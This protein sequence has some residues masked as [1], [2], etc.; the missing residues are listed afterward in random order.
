MSIVGIYVE[1][2]RLLAARLKQAKT[3][4]EICALTENEKPDG[5]ST[6]ISGLEGRELILRKLSFGLKSRRAI[7][8]AL[9]F[10]AEGALPYAPE[11]SLLLPFFSKKVDGK[12]DVTLSATTR[13]QLEQHLEKMRSLQLDPDQVSSIPTAIFRFARHFLQEEPHLFFLH[14]GEKESICG[15]IL[16]KELEQFYAFSLGASDFLEDENAAEQRLE[17]ELDRALAFLKKK[18]PFSPEKLLLTGEARLMEKLKHKIENFSHL[19]I[20]EAPSAPA[21]TFA[22][23]L[24]LAL[25]GLAKDARKIQ[26]RQNEFLSVRAQ[27]KRVKQMSLFFLSC[28][29]LTLLTWLST[30]LLLGKER[31]VLREQLHRIH[32][33]SSALPSLEEGITNCETALS[34]EKPPFPMN[35]SAPKVCDLLAWLSTHPKL[36]QEIDLK[37]VR[38]ELVKHP[39][40]NGPIEPY[41]AKV[42]LKFSSTTPLAARQ[43]REALMKGDKLVN[44]KQEISWNLQQNVYQTTFFLNRVQP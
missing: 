27:K 29:T 19:K 37:E 10:Q 14:L 1:G 39:K 42:E 3:G 33:A 24:G 40:L 43:F 9:P 34:K 7:L 8:K 4:V 32:P 16:E 2:E 18:T 11:E 20:L 22:I 26:F 12:Y 6:I 15:L 36:T 31:K 35:S 30:S 38:Y 17:K 25:D 41:L 28:I 44:A 23:P 13:T 21:S 5:L